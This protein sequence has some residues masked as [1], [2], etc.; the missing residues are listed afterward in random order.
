MLLRYDAAPIEL[1]YRLKP[2]SNR[3]EALN[4]KF[5]VRRNS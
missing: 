3:N 4:T 1:L 5:T 2:T